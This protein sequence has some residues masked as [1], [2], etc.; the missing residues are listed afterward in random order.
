MSLIKLQPVVWDC[1]YH[2]E[3]IPKYR[4]KVFNREIREAVI[5]EI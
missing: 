2:I 1:K 3:I 4:Y 5:D